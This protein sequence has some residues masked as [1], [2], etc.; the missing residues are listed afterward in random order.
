MADQDMLDDVPCP[1]LAAQELPGPLE[2]LIAWRSS[3]ERI[4]SLAL[5]D[6]S[7]SL[8]TTLLLGRHSGARSRAPPK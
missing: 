6:R 7:V 1:P 8:H 3:H 4:A 2:L 5:P